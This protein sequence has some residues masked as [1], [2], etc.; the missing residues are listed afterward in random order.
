MEANLE[1]R[2]L[3]KATVFDRDIREIIYLLYS[4]NAKVV[5]FEDLDRFHNLEIFI[6]L[7]EINFILNSYIRRKIFKRKPV[8][9]IYMINDELFS[10]HI[11]TKF[12]DFIVPVLPV[13]NSSNSESKFCEFLELI[14]ELDSLDKNVIWKISLY[15]SDIR[16]IKNIVNEFFIYNY[17]INSENNQIDKNKLF[18]L[19][20]LKNIMP[21]EF[22]LLQMDKG[23]I[24]NIFDKIKKYKI[25]N[26]DSIKNEL[27]EAKNKL[28]S[29]F[30][31]YSEF[32][33]NAALLK[34]IIF[35]FLKTNMN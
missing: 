15:I 16:L 25:N 22:D 24:F 34:M 32:E 9:F 1:E 33:S 3:P 20:T 13:I 28:S 11:R 6:K 31:N 30:E 5:V 21:K 14:G 2:Y 19:I 10:P 26:I 35:C 12:F 23:Y 4:S 8:K 29:L 17:A 7:K 18:A 27:N